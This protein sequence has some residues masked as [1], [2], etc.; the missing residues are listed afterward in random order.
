MGRY[1]GHDI[2]DED[3]ECVRCNL[4]C[5]V[6][7]EAHWRDATPRFDMWHG[8]SRETISGMEQPL[9]MRLACY[10]NHCGINHSRTFRLM[11]GYEAI[12]TMEEYS[13]PHY[14][15]DLPVLKEEVKDLEWSRW[16][17]I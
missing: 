4:P 17:D 1:L 14:M 2:S 6:R 11:N 12:K 3:L 8:D 10:C 5:E 7:L 9:N 16:E 13:F 15:P